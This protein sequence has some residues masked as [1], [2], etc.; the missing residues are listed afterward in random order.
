MF[1]FFRGGGRGY[2]QA[3]S[4]GLFEVVDAK[5]ASA[6]GQMRSFIKRICLVGAFLLG[7]R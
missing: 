1:A 6:A 2:L 4:E 7:E 3:S 5:L